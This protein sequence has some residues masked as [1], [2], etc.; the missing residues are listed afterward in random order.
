MKRGLLMIG[1]RQRTP[2]YIITW[3]IREW[4]VLTLSLGLAFIVSLVGV[5]I[6]FGAKVSAFFAPHARQPLVIFIANFLVVWLMA[7]LIISYRRWRREALKNRE[8]SDIVDSISPDVLLVVNPDRTILMT[9][10]S[11]LRMFGHTPESLIGK[12]TDILYGDRRSRTDIKHEIYEA[13]QTEGFHIG[14]ANGMR[15]DGKMF[16]LEIITGIL[17]DHSGSVLLLRDISER[18]HAEKMLMDREVQLRQSQKMEALGQLA[19]EVAHDFNNLLTSILGFSTQ[20][21]EA[22]PSE[23]PAQEDIKEVLNSASRAAKL[24]SKLLAVGRK[25]SFQIDRINLNEVVDGMVHLLK[26]TLGEK[27]ALEIHLDSESS[28]VSADLGGI[29]QIILNLAVNARDAM[30]KGGTLEIRTERLI[31]DKE[32]NRPNMSVAPGAYVVLTVRDSGI[33]MSQETQE[34]IFEPFFTTKERGRGTG[35]GL[36]MV[37]GI[38]RQCSGS[39]EVESHPGVGTTF[40]LFFKAE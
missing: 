11:T 9:S 37:Y 22:L 5:A 16:P 20:V 38:M 30:P 2:L 34:H 29:E 23:H 19:G 35:L 10:R 21:A 14:W 17:A 36:S 1:K 33:G 28:T 18:K 32:Y 4:R 40:R 15:K 6:N 7:L 3:S 13:L 12:K 8:L 39:I 26:R 31:L 25:Q 24:T 27:V